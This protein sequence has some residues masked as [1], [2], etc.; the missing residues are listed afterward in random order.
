[1]NIN[2][3]KHQ[4]F[5]YILIA[6]IFLFFSLMFVPF[7]TPLIFAILFSFALDPIVSK[8][9][10]KKSKRKV[11]TL[12]IL[13]F[14]LL[15]IFLPIGFVSHRLV[16][17]LTEVARQG[18][19][20]TH[21][22]NQATVILNK[23]SYFG[24]PLS[25]LPN[26]IG[27]W[28]LGFSTNFVSK[29]PE[30]FMGLFVFSLALYFLLTESKKIK[31]D[32]L[33]LDLMDEN[34]LNRLI[35]IV[36]KSSYNTI[37]IAAIVGGV[38]A[39]IVAT[40]GWFFSYKEFLILFF[41]TFFCS[42]IPFVGAGTVAAL[43]A[44]FSFMQEDYTGTIGM[45]V[46]CLVAGSIDNILKPILLSNSASDQE[47]NPIISLLAIIGGVIVYGAPGLL[48]GPILT[49]LVLNIGQ[50]NITPPVKE[51]SNNRAL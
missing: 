47:T 29:M 11:P 39:L 43:L 24:I 34:E 13:L 18:F 9:G 20:H 32:A 1:M 23:I 31:K 25:D 17:K 8:Y 3:D 26:K 45:A 38:Q 44:F 5:R 36:Q 40:G 49:Q 10:I 19:Q 50:L 35:N 30:F 42:F 16:I 4:T 46:I 2:I 51:D 21:I 37:V 33:Q 22:Y 27:T 41:V 15:I 12:F 7:V 28:A 6:L 14:S 48:I